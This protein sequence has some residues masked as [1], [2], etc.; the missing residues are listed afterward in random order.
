MMFVKYPEQI[1]LPMLVS[2]PS[3]LPK[4]LV[5]KIPCLES[6]W[7]L[8]NSVIL[9]LNSAGLGRLKEFLFPWRPLIDVKERISNALGQ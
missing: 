1:L 3:L 2:H 9:K 4:D 6:C 5:I 8:I 7:L